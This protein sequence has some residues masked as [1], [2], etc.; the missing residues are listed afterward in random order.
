M[1]EQ[2]LQV[3][4]LGSFSIRW[5]D[6][7]EL[8]DNS[9]RMRKI[10][11]LLAYL[12]YRRACV[13]QEELISL[14]WDEKNE[15]ANP[16]GALKTTFS[17]IRSMLNALDESAGQI[18]IL[19][20][21]GGYL[22][23]P[24]IPMTLDIEEFE[25]L[26]RKASAE[27]DESL[28]LQLYRR[29]LALYQG[30]F[31]SKLSTDPW[32]IPISTY[33]HQLYLDAVEGTLSLLEER[34]LWTEVSQLCVAA[35][36]LE[37]YS[38]PLHC[39]L[40]RSYLALGDPSGAVNVYSKLSALLLADFGIMPSAE[41]RALCHS[42]ERSFYP[43]VLQISDIQEQLQKDRENP[44]P[45]FCECD[46]FKVLCQAQFRA[47]PPNGDMAHIAQ[48]SLQGRLDKNLSRRSL[49][50]ATGNLKK[51]L[52]QNLRRRDILTQCSI[53]QFLLLLPQTSYAESCKTCED[54]VRAFSRRYPHSPALIHYSVQPL[55]PSSSQ[56]DQ[57]CTACTTQR[58]S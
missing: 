34:R 17:R 48:F 32:V 36:K 38:E 19:R 40:M 22:W 11:L 15:H 25:A 57:H 21:N 2:A 52:I 47:M 30:D 20:Q 58:F 9:N 10:W 1:N 23:N 24:D 4:M 27:E 53:S 49:D 16:V 6:N 26:C 8:S 12:I 43:A 33:F 51:L 55:E 3:R 5:M 7:A 13:S 37:P 45:M 41:A 42:A 31:L 14:L 35:L 46:V 29:A 56:E 44:G 50:T 39:H 18:L 28:R 54:L